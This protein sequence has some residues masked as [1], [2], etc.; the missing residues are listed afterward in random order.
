MTCLQHGVDEPLL[1]P[2]LHP[3]VREHTAHREV[4]ATGT[5]AGVVS[6]RGAARVG[7]QALGL[8]A[9]ELVPW[10]GV[11]VRGWG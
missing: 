7:H 2:L 9:V 1:V 10:L 6:E 5:L 8:R 3:L 4:R 11:G